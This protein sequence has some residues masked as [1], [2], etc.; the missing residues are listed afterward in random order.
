VPGPGTV[1]ITY[2]PD[3]GGQPMEFDIASFTG[4]GVVMCVY[5]YDD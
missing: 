5:N 1:T 4:G 2:Q 3:D